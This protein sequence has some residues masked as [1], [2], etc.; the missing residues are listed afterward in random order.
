MSMVH[1]KSN[2]LARIKK[3][4]RVVLIHNGPKLVSRKG[5]VH[6]VNATPHTYLQSR[7]KMCYHINRVGPNQIKFYLIL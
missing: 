6:N 3:I 5:V 1:F 7:R 2:I 4:S